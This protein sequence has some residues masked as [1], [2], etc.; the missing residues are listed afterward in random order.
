MYQSMI[1]MT[2]DRTMSRGCSPAPVG[3]AVTHVGPLSRTE[4]FTWRSFLIVGMT[5]AAVAEASGE[6]SVPTECDR[7][8]TFTPA[9]FARTTYD[10]GSL[11]SRQPV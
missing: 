6:N 8:I 4:G 11:P 1:D 3:V 2:I 5:D 10:P 9:P 7:S